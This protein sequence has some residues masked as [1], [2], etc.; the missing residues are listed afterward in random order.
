M[1]LRGVAMRRILA[2]TDNVIFTRSPRSVFSYSIRANG[3]DKME[4]NF[5]VIFF[6]VLITADAN[7]RQTKCRRRALT[8]KI[9][10][11]FKNHL[12]D[13][14][15]SGF[16][17]GAPFFIRLLSALQPS[18]CVWLRRVVSPFVFVASFFPHFSFTLSSAVL[19]LL[20]RFSSKISRSMCVSFFCV[21]VNTLYNG[22]QVQCARRTCKLAFAQSFRNRR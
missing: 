20:Q 10:K 18:F 12:V 21:N 11:T 13:R 2:F 9:N 3:R 15:S 16:R 5:C 6:S 8:R 1:V 7:E 19:L 17:I 22:V 4:C 14:M